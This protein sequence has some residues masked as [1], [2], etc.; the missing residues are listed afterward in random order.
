MKFLTKRH[1]LFLHDTLLERD[2]GEPGFLNESAL[3]S[4]LDAPRN[5]HGYEGAGLA[6]CAATY[7]FHLTKAHAF[8]D[9]NKRIG[10]AAA[11][12]FLNVNGARLT[13]TES[14]FHDMV[15]AIAASKMTR[16]EVDAWFASRVR[17]SPAE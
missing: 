13:T 5:R 12:T 14:D 10:A 15:L 6:T 1:I 8:V 3:D 4:A 17:E 11:T 2:G 9:G 7:A 16:D